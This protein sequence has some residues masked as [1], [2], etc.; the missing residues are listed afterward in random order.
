VDCIGHATGRLLNRR[1]PYPIDLERC[2]E[3][4]A[5]TGTAF[6]ING[7]PHRRDLNEIHARMAAEAGVKLVL[8]TDAHRPGDLEYMFFAVATARR[9]WLAT[10][11]ILNT[12]PWWKA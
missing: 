5:A 12:G 2:F 11:R 10:S 6:E 3:R 4:A 9:A 8:N 1:Q 7:N